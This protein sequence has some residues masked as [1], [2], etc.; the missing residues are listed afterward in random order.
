MKPNAAVS[1]SRAVLGLLLLLGA[2]GVA[3]AGPSPAPSPPAFTIL[4]SPE[5]DPEESG[6]PVFPN[7]VPTPD[8]VAENYYRLAREAWQARTDVPFVH[9]GALIRYE[10]NNHVFD[11][12][13]D[14]YFR[15][16]DGELGLERLTDPDEDR[17]RLGGVPFSI[18]GIT[19][20]DTNK[21]SEP[22]QI[23]DPRIEPTFSFGLVS[24]R[25]SVTQ[26]GL[27]PEPSAEPSSAF[28]QIAVVATRTRA[29]D[30]RYVGTSRIGNVDAIH[31][32]F[33]PLQ[34]AR[35]DRLRELW[36]DPVS[37]RTM[38]LRVQGI[39]NGKPYDGVSWH[40]HYVE[41]DG[42]NYLQQVV[43]DDARHF[44]IGVTIPRLEFDF[45][46][47]HFPQT[48]PPYTFGSKIF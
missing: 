17:K 37:H 18:F 47:Y 12:W 38:Q 10:H 26:G 4:P 3:H 43:A 2:A 35:A 34:D 13:W 6:I 42:R 11:N 30:V 28:P 20:F 36:M 32:T 25:S 7:G 27:A 33:T 24:R 5:P 15:S 48:V 46:D 21:N 9:Y 40:I 8:A 29:Y 23:D 19:I 31:L 1:L 16:K 14:A 39:L 41:L 45:F 22:I 44:G